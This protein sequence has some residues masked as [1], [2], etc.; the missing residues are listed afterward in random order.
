MSGSNILIAYFTWTENTYAENPAGSRYSST[1][2]S[3]M[4]YFAEDESGS[5]P[6]F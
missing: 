6:Y 3:G 4:A 2:D 1:A 5:L